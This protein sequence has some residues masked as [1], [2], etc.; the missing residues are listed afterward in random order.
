MVVASACVAEMGESVERSVRMVPR[1]WEECQGGSGMSSV[2]VG[3][4]MPWGRWVVVR[5][6]LV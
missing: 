1:L 3:S 2:Q 6:D 4:V 5:S